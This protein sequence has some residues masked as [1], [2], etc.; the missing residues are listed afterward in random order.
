MMLKRWKHFEFG[1]EISLIL[2]ET[3]LAGKFFIRH[4]LISN[5]CIVMAK[6]IEQL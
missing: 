2:D 6:G 3:F 5:L 1:N 4:V